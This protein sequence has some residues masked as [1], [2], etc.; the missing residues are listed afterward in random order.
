MF[1]SHPIRGELFVQPGSSE[2]LDSASLG[3]G[4]EPVQK[5][6][7]VA[8]P[9]GWALPGAFLAELQATPEW[10]GRGEGPKQ[11]GGLAPQGGSQEWGPPVR[12]EVLCCSG[13]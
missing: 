1:P 2:P 4:P 11:D 10:E 8:A 9:E 3:K 7:S 6:S 5:A 13:S 12:G